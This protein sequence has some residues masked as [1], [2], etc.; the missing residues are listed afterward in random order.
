MQWRQAPIG[1]AVLIAAF[2]DGRA[3]QA[4]EWR[5]CLAPSSPQHTVY[6]STPFPADSSMADI[7]AAFGRA[8]DDAQLRHDS[9]Q[10]PRGDA[11]AI[12]GM[13]VQAIQYSQAS[14]NRVVQ[15]NWRP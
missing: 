6:M 9:V 13:K 11:Q 5:Y 10:C 2:L 8:L 3:A 4:A 12:A 15:L 1:I 14:G 7:E